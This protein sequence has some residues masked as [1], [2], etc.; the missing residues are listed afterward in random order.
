MYLIPQWMV[1]AAYALGSLHWSRWF[2]LAKTSLVGVALATAAAVF[3]LSLAAYSVSGFETT[4]LP[5]TPQ[6]VLR[7]KTKPISSPHTTY[8][9]DFEG[10]AL[11]SSDDPADNFP[12]LNYLKYYRKIAR[13]APRYPDEIHAE[14]ESIAKTLKDEQVSPPAK[15]AVCGPLGETHESRHRLFWAVG[16]NLVSCDAQGAW[17]TVLP[18]ADLRE[19]QRDKTLFKGSHIALVKEKN[20][21]LF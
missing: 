14:L 3:S 8:V 18:A 6:T 9:L 16:L 10:I 13:N 21:A 4:I 17:G 20:E 2:S 12:M 15:L 11:E 7:F 1:L 19:T 5:L